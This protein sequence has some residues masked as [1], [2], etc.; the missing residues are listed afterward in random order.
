M[1][2][3]GIEKQIA[4]I[5]LADNSRLVNGERKNLLFSHYASS[6]GLI[7][8]ALACDERRENA[9]RLKSAAL[10]KHGRAFNPNVS[11]SLKDLTVSGPLSLHDPS[12]SG[13]IIN[14]LLGDNTLPGQSVPAFDKS[15]RRVMDGVKC[16]LN[17][18]VLFN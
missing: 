13:G 5:N 17:G 3:P 15:S 18:V 14:N 11:N 8:N 12:I 2:L 7:V 6:N 16:L 4:E 1:C 10:D 9:T